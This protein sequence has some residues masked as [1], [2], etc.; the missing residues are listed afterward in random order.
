MITKEQ[1]I[2]L[3]NGS[4]REDI[5]TTKRGP[6][7]RITGPRGGVAEHIVRV[8]RNGQCKTWK[9]RPTEFQL[10]YKYG[11]YEHGYIT[12]SNASDFH[13]ASD[14]PLNT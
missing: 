2:A 12:E 4:L 13:L 11:M 9:T 6:C 10:P 8:R 5:H 7:T 14:C 3:G 1:A